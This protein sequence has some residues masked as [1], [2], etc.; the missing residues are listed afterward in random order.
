FYGEYVETLIAQLTAALSSNFAPHRAPG[1][2]ARLVFVCSGQG[3]QWLGMARSLLSGESAYR[4]VIERC[5]H[6]VRERYGWSL[7][8]ELVADEAHSRLAQPEVIQLT[9]V[10]IQIALG[11]LWRSWGVEPDAFLGHSVGEVAACCLAGALS[12]EQ[13]LWIVGERARLVSDSARREGGMLNVNVPEGYGANELRELAPDLEVGA[14]NSPRNLVL[15]GSLD[16]VAR[17]ERALIAIGAGCDRVKTTYASHSAHMDPLLAPLRARLQGL[18]PA[19]GNIPVRS[20][21]RP[22]WLSGSECGP[23]YWA[24]N[25]RH[26]VRFQDAIEEAAGRED[27]LFVELS[28]H[29]L[30]LKAIQQTLAG[31]GCTTLASCYRGE[32]ERRSMLEALR[33]LYYAG[34]AIA[35]SEVFGSA[36]GAVPVPAARLAELE[37]EFADEAAGEQTATDVRLPF[38]LSARS[39]AALQA[40]AH[41]LHE[42][43]LERPGLALADVA[44][45]LVARRAAFDTRAV[46]VASSRG[47]LLGGLQQLERGETPACSVIGHAS[48]VHKLAF[49]FPGQGSQWVGMARELLGQS[50]VFASEMRACEEALHAF[51][52]WSLAEVLRTA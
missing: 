25:L 37:Q 2:R 21:A 19:D 17:A 48:A 40:Q 14:Y 29:P 51:V 26:P 33:E 6:I 23:D 43:L 41:D 39:E 18:A 11:T 44:H 16:A 36:V 24:D 46:L 38:V 20:T 1:E 3:A 47:G 49:V 5:D 10:S 7:I 32:D 13:A 9:L 35:W 52:P 30:L 15:S 45:S 27:A 12:I 34:A 31:R 8:D 50:E 28:T 42:Y 22:G 4:T